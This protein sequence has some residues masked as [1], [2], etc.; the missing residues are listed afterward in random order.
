MA[1]NPDATTAKAFHAERQCSAGLNKVS[2][3][4][5]VMR[6]LGLRILATTIATF[7]TFRLAST[8]GGNEPYAQTCVLLR[9]LWRRARSSSTHNKTV[10]SYYEGVRSSSTSFSQW[11]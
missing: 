7:V 3:T 11:A 2:N 10:S 4:G 1:V 8:L 9:L 5:T 6:L